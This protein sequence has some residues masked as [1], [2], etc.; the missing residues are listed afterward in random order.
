MKQATKKR[1]NRIAYGFGITI[2]VVSHIYLL[3]TGSLPEDMVKDH[4]IINLVAG[5]AL[6]YSW[7]TKK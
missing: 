5:G 6:A 1:I 2:V 4:A 7:F 3:M